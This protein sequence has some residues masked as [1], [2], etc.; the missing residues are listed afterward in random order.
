VADEKIIRG[1][2][3]SGKDEATGLIDE[4]CHWIYV[5]VTQS[6]K[7]TL[8]RWHSRKLVAAKHHVIVYD[9]V[10]TA[11]A[12]GGW[13]SGDD[14]GSGFDFYEDPEKFMEAIAKA[15]D[16]FVFIDESADTHS[17]AQV[18]NHW[19]LR[20]GRHAGLYIRLLVQRVKMLPPNVRT[21]CARLFLFRAS[22]TDQREIL[23]DFGHEPDI[24]PDDWKKG[25]C[26]MVESGSSEVEH[27]NVF[28]LT[29]GDPDFVERVEKP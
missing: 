18:E 7:T 12:G 20:R 3:G 11:T 15:K 14:G 16:A 5:G 8:A 13:G 21:Q 28:E 27:F 23:A 26:L 19:L 1:K 17:H 2:R 29:G 24:L 22:R 25:D 6:G 4:A 9:P 10:G